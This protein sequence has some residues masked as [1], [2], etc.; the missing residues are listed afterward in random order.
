MCVPSEALN[1]LADIARCLDLIPLSKFTN[2]N[3]YLVVT[4]CRL[5]LL[6]WRLSHLSPDP[7]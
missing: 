3:R 6:P 5:A 4:P 2:Q 1:H 7:I